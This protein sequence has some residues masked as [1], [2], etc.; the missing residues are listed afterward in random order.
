MYYLLALNVKKLFSILIYKCVKTSL[1]P[2]SGLEK[3]PNPKHCTG[4]IC[5]FSEKGLFRQYIDPVSDQLKNP[6][7][8]GGLSDIG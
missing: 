4:M 8:R 5:N 3:V 2:E 1:G 7:F 6:N